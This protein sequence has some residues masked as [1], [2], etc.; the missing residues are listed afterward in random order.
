MANPVVYG[1][2]VISY[3]LYLWHTVPLYFMRDHNVFQSWG[4]GENFLHLQVFSYTV[5]LAIALACVSYFAVERPFLRAKDQ[6]ST[7]A[8]ATTAHAPGIGRLVAM[9]LLCIVWTFALE[10]YKGPI[11]APGK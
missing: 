6:R 1:L 5:P 4:L 8:A 7:S 3:S 2:G 11:A 10:L 9:G